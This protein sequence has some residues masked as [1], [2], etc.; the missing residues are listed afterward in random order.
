M[1]AKKGEGMQ[2]LLMLNREERDALNAM[3][4]EELRSPPQQAIVLLRERLK[5]FGYLNSEKRSPE[6]HA[7]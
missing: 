6:E 2:V 4:A 5:R 1:K 3:A 7:T